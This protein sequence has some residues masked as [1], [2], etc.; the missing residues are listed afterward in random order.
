M[1]RLKCISSYI[2]EN[3]KVIDVGCDQAQL[4]II[5]AKRKIY[6]IASDLRPNIIKNAEK[7]VPEELKKYI[8]FR[9]G[10]GITLKENEQNYTL[11]ISGMGTNLILKILNSTNHK[12]KKIITISNNH[13]ENLRIG[14]QKLGYK[15]DKEEIIKEKNKYYNLIIF[16]IGLSSYKKDEILIGKNHQNL[17]LLKEKNKKLINKYEKIIKEIP[18][19]KDKKE[20]ET[21]I[22]ILKKYNSFLLKKRKSI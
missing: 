1:N 18:N 12:F 21:K 7:N 2:N 5:L 6:S 13:H 3:E 17:D 11:T 16:V 20:L 22:E 10:D 15:I 4:S 9:I 14:M 8:K 19:N